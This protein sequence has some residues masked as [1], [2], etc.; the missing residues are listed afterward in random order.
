MQSQW[1]LAEVKREAFFPASQ[2]LCPRIKPFN[3]PRKNQPLEYSGSRYWMQLQSRDQRV[4]WDS[5]EFES[6][7]TCY[8]W[9][10]CHSVSWW[11]SP[12]HH[13]FSWAPLMDSVGLH[14]IPPYSLCVQSSRERQRQFL[15]GKGLLHLSQLRKLEGFIFSTLLS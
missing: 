2:Y 12:S 13:T 6:F 4:L 8:L 10:K 9:P 3:A 14:R 1:S 15:L 11:T 7:Q 5:E